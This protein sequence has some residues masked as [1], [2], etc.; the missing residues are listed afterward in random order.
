[1]NA[2][3]Y[4]IRDLA[5]RWRCSDNTVRAMIRRGRAR[6]IATCDYVI[7]VGRKAG[8]V[9]EEGNRGG[10][11][12]GGAGMHAACAQALGGMPSC[13]ERRPDGRDQRVSRSHRYSDDDQALCPFPPGLSAEG[14]G[15]AGAVN[16]VLPG[17][18]RTHQTNRP[19]TKRHQMTNEC[20][21]IAPQGIDCASGM[22]IHIAG[23]TGSSPVPPTKSN[24]RLR[25]T[26]WRRYTEPFV[27]N[28]TAQSVPAACL[29]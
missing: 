25:R 9:G 23:V 4:R 16:T 29:G 21:R 3:A 28:A 13:G 14:G 26:C 20:T 22:R 27:A 10:G 17:P 19:E 24:Q 6:Q 5:K 18:L 8:A 12:T 11:Q 2:C 15:G 7:E 1:M